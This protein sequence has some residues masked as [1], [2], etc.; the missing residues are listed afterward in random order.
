MNEKFTEFVNSNT[1]KNTKKNA[2]F[3]LDLLDSKNIE[4]SSNVITDNE[5]LEN[6]FLQCNLNSFNSIINFRALLKSYAIFINDKAL[7]NLV[8]KVD[9]Y[10]VLEKIKPNMKHS[11]I[12]S[13]D[14]NDIYNAIGAYD[15]NTFSYN[16]LYYKTLFWS[17]YEGIY[18]E[19]MS[20]LKNLRA[21]DIKGNTVT[22]HSDDGDEWEIDI[23]KQLVADVMELSNTFVWYRK[24]RGGLCEIKIDG[25]CYD[26]VFKVEIRTE[27]SKYS[28]RSSYYTRLHKISEE[29]IGY[30]VS[31]KNLFFSGIINRIK[32]QYGKSDE[33]F[34]QSV[35]NSDK[36]LIDIYDKEAKRCHYSVPF[37]SFRQTIIGRI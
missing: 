6:I 31:P 7:F 34:I 4:I 21:S 36:A 12:S 27:N 37:F 20:V 25:L 24:N 18:C 2:K 17:I 9:I 33:D 13:S 23:P 11:Y 8:R 32:K 14:F 1:N 5:T 16:A 30:F 22:L 35:S 3:Y 29:Y 10:K 28:Y 19:D 15:E 26:S